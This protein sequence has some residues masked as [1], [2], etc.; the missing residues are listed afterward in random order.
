VLVVGVVGAAALGSVWT[1]A[2]ADPAALGYLLGV[3]GGV[4]CFVF[5]SAFAAAS[6]RNDDFRSGYVQY[7]EDD[8]GDKHAQQ[9][10]EED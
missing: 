1:G 9:I 4:M 5:G 10:L 8:Y 3:G 6:F 2:R 7:S